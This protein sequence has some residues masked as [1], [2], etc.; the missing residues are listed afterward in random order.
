MNFLL[1]DWKGEMGYSFWQFKYYKPA[2]KECES[3]IQW[4]TS[5]YSHLLKTVRE[6]VQNVPEQQHPWC[7]FFFDNLNRGFTLDECNVLSCYA[8]CLFKIIHSSYS[9]SCCSDDRSD[10]SLCHRQTKRLE[11]PVS[12]SRAAKFVKWY[13]WKDGGSLGIRNMNFDPVTLSI[14]SSGVPPHPK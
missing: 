14:M 10:V 13:W 11:G 9:W 4:E 8:S 12:A 1:S 5:Y 2:V 6:K 7:T 3:K